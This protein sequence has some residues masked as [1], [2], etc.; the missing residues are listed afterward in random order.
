LDE[1]VKNIRIVEFGNMECSCSLSS[2][3]AMY[4]L[5]ESFSVTILIGVIYIHIFIIA[6]SILK[7]LRFY[8]LVVSDS[9]LCTLLV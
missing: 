8:K 4:L 9:Y 3:T 2:N 1:T 5:Y 6:T 7:I